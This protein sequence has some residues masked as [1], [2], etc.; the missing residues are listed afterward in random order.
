MAFRTGSAVF[1]F[2]SLTFFILCSA[3]ARNPSFFSNDDEAWSMVGRSLKT[4][5]LED[6][7]EPTANPGHDP[8]KACNWGNHV[9]GRTGCN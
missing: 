2:L 7:S 4:V 3:T 6:Y 9:E 8:W 1:F 5:N